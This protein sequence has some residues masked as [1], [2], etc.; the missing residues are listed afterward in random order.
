M[1]V[2][3]AE[4][5]TIHLEGRC[6]IEDAEPL[7]QLL[8]QEAEGRVDLR[9]CQHAHTA[10]IQILFAARPAILGPSPALF[11]RDWIEPALSGA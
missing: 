5:G 4:D 3:R 11:L 9:A 7:L 8:L 6:P 2:R 1:T 10:V